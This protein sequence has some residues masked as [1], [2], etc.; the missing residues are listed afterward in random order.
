MYIVHCI[1]HTPFLLSRSGIALWLEYFKNHNGGM[2]MFL[3][4]LEAVPSI[5]CMHWNKFVF[6]L[7][8]WFIRFIT[9][10]NLPW[11][12]YKPWF[13]KCSQNLEG[14]KYQKST[15][16]FIWI[17]FKTTSQI[18]Y[19]KFQNSNNFIYISLFAEQKSV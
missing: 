1:L 15:E 9:E 2:I 5:I 14:K 13:L 4:R 6:E 12:K 7:G 18:L 10:I 11:W 3:W 8:E 16:L 17:I 19:Q